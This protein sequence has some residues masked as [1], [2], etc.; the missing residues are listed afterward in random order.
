MKTL[1]VTTTA[2]IISPAGDRDMFH[3][4]NN[5]D[6]VIYLKFDGSSVALTTANGYP[7]PV[8]G[9]LDLNCE[10]SR[11]TYN[12]EIWAIHGGSGNKEVRIQG[13]D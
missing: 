1:N 4:Y 6:E 11:R 13:E 12:R 5:S 9:Y 2:A 7:I 8:G 3:I 10:G